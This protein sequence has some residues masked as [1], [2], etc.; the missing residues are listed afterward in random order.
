VSQDKSVTRA[1]QWSRAKKI[2]DEWKLNNRHWR[3]TPRVKVDSRERKKKP[4][5]IEGEKK[6]KTAYGIVTEGGKS[7]T[8][9]RIKEKNKIGFAP[10]RVM[11]SKPD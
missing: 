7:T 8:Q 3:V 2:R 9:L 5:I 6:K 4:I 1:P 10:H 11:F